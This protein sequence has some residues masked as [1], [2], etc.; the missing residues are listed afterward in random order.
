MSSSTT[1]STLSAALLR[2]WSSLTTR[3]LAANVNHKSF[4]WSVLDGCFGDHFVDELNDELKAANIF[5]KLLQA[6]TKGESS[7][8]GSVLSIAPVRGDKSIFL[9]R[10]Y[11]GRG[12]FR[13]RHPSL[14]RLIS[15]IS[16]TLV[17]NLKQEIEFDT[18]LTSVQLA[19]YPGDRKA[20]YIRHCDRGQ[21]SCLSESPETLAPLSP[22][23]IITAIYYL[24]DEDWDPVL[25][26][27]FLRVLSS[28]STNS[29][30]ICPY[31]DR[32]VIFRSDGVEH[33]VMP[34]LRRQRTAITIWF[35]GNDKRPSSELH[36]EGKVFSQAPPNTGKSLLSRTIKTTLATNKILPLLTKA[37]ILE[38]QNPPTIFVSIASYRDSETVPTIDA[39]FETSKYPHRIFVG[40]V[41]Q[42]DQRHDTELGIGKYHDN[43]NVRC[44]QLDS[45]FALGPCYA[46]SLAQSLHQGESFVLQIDSHM[47]FRPNWDEYLVDLLLKTAKVNNNPKVLLTAYPVGYTLPNDVPMET[48]GTLLVPWKFDNNGMLRQRG[49]LLQPTTDTAIPCRLY[50]AGFNFGLSSIIKDVP[51]DPTLD[52]LFFGEELSMAV[53][54]YTHGYDL[55]SPSE[56][57][58]FHLWSRSHRPTIQSSKSVI[59]EKEKEERRKASLHIVRQQL[60]GDDYRNNAHG[61][62]TTR[63]ANQFSNALG[64]DF[65]TKSIRDEAQIGVL[66]MDRFVDSGATSLA[67]DDSFEQK[68]ACLDSKSLQHI[69]FFLGEMDLGAS[70]N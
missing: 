45:R 35:Y 3:L 2:G 52:F 70:Y 33:Q 46:R 57:V 53:R 59:S 36:T 61:L 49:R 12:D 65:R 6:R 62:G 68:V 16:N 67:A 48:R 20:G 24:T 44:L 25:D 50:A 42:N 14:H 15:T 29:T 32:L 30:D 7:V 38:E 66:A 10:E 11:R 5:D 41:L 18:S 55:Y 60:L 47:R 51:Y 17:G 54:F 31:R 39:L 4:A 37:P 58:V 63:T 26:E 21:T 27:G 23:R 19:I 22:Q 8:L 9:S 56:T 13:A 1:P 34:S 43:N 64:V 40:L 28:N 69:S